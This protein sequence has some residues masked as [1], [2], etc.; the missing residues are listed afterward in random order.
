MY[1]RAAKTKERKS[2]TILIGS[3]SSYKRVIFKFE[4][5]FFAPFLTSERGKT[6]KIMYSHLYVKSGFLCNE[7][8]GETF[9]LH[10][11]HSP[12]ASPPQPGTNL[13]PYSFRFCG[14]LG[15]ME[16]KKKKKKGKVFASSHIHHHKICIQQHETWRKSAIKIDSSF[17]QK[18]ARSDSFHRHLFHPHKELMLEAN[19]ATFFFSIPYSAR[20]KH[21][22]VYLAK[23]TETFSNIACT[24]EAEQH[25][26]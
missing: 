3:G 8:R 24:M 11:R 17:L 23:E 6:P 12:R 5:W 10:H 21:L 13:F 19:M 20:L 16:W 1:T 9:L 4:A 7:A 18:L 15:G 14:G 25:R 2:C 22:L 26:T